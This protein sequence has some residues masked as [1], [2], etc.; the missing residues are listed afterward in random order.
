MV[1]TQETSAAAG[2]SVHTPVLLKET[3]EALAPKRGQIYVD[4]TI[5]GGGHALAMLE[6]ASGELRIIG[7]DQDRGAILR[8]RERLSTARPEPQFVKANFRDIDRAL[9]EVGMGKVDL[10]LLDLGLSSDEL[11]NSGRGFS[12]QRDEPLLM[13]YDDEPES[14]AITAESIVNDKSEKE[15]ADI[16]WEYGEERFSRQIA[17]A[18][19]ARR[20]KE[21]IRTSADLAAVIEQAVPK[22]F[23][24]RR[25]HPATKTFQAIRMAVNEELLSLRECLPLAFERLSAGGRLAVISFH[26]LEDRIVKN[27]FR[28]KSKSGQGS[29]PFTKPVRPSREEISRNPR[30]RSAKLRV[31]EKVS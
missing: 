27:F 3:V 15:L 19:V 21:R 14:G 10:I 2:A 31:I 26:S 6:A 7:I 9:Q 12:F 1:E 29:L 24:P 13:T 30:A 20:K 28:D 4:G 16:I 25:T 23:Q 5:G 22:F 18:I 8:A 17:R 11:Q